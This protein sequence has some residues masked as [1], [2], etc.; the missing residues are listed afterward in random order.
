M[1][2]KS[3]K[4][5]RPFRVVVRQSAMVNQIEIET[6]GGVGVYDSDEFTANQWETLR[7]MVAETWIETYLPK[8]IARR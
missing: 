3:K 2:K 4:T 5:M 6:A 7:G 8:A 1:A